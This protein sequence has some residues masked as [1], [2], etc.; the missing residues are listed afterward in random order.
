M[1]G[2]NFYQTK[3]VKNCLLEDDLNYVGCVES[4][5]PETQGVLVT[6]DNDY[7]KRIVEKPKEFVGN[8]VNASL[9]KFTPDIFDAVE[10]I[11]IS[12]RGEFEITDAITLLAKEHKV[13]ILRL[14]EYWIDF[15]KPS[16]IPKLSRFIKSESR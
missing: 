9:Y 14:R 11:K 6:D 8:L 1:A 13:K 5:H 15:G 7:L 3:D 10:K 4:E 2:D 16:D 12:P